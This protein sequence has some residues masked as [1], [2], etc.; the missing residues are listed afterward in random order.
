M[1]RKL[2]QAPSTRRCARFA[3]YLR[4]TP[5]ISNL[6]SSVS[7]SLSQVRSFSTPA[8]VEEYYRHGVDTNASKRMCFSSALDE[9]DPLSHE[10]YRYEV[11]FKAECSDVQF[12]QEGGFVTLDADEMGRVFPTG[13]AGE[14][15]GD[16]FMVRDSSK[17]LCRLMEDFESRCKIGTGVSSLPVGHRYPVVVPG[18][19]DLPQWDNSS[20]K[21]F[22]Y[23]NDD[24]NSGVDKPETPGG[25][26]MIVRGEGSMVEGVVQQLQQKM[27]AQL[28][29]RVMLTGKRGVG[30]S[31]ALNHA[32][33][34]ARTRGWICIFIPNG[35]SHVNG[36]AFIEPV[37]EVTGVENLFD[38]TM[39]SADLL[40]KF[41]F[42]HKEDL[43]D[44][45]LQFPEHAEKYRESIEVLQEAVTRTYG[46]MKKSGK[47]FTEIR[48][49]EVGFD[50]TFPD[51]DALDAPILNQTSNFDI[52]SFEIKTVEDLVLFGLAF[53]DFAGPVVLDMVRELRG[54]KNPDKPILIAIDQFNYWD[55]PT[56]YQYG[57]V[58]I[59][60]MDMCVP[61][62][63]KFLSEK[64]NSA[65]RWENNGDDNVMCIGATSHRYPI[66]K[67]KDK[68]LVTYENSR[69]SLP[70]S[71]D[72]GG[73]SHVE[74]L[75]AVKHYISTGRIDPGISNQDI[76]SFRMFCGNN[77]RT[78][79]REPS[80]FFL[81]LQSD[82]VSAVFEKITSSGGGGG[83]ETFKAIMRDQDPDEERHFSKEDVHYEVK[84]EEDSGAEGGAEKDCDVDLSSLNEAEV[85]AYLAELTTEP[86]WDD[87]E[88]T[89]SNP[90]EPRGGDVEISFG[91]R[92]DDLL[93]KTAD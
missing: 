14:L 28:P 42:A 46:S 4:S 65:T 32:V 68:K 39:M 58:K 86:V 78:M 3:S 25:E 73:Y 43:R 57:E 72:M 55:M 23:S 79:F 22:S 20:T 91:G 40:R 87:L 77:P 62:A 80:N 41:W 10:I 29:T 19:T 7:P 15:D 2:A 17:L 82:Y 66:N 36:G 48:M 56:V 11:D 71:I 21:V 49:A 16:A 31:C 34:H 13:M 61:H 50:D 8:S 63:L 12:T 64:K 54:Y 75:A 70:L 6:Y 18:L 67:K 30:K 53:R 44:I 33:Y 59:D 93:R 85:Q 51:E 90:L 74:F 35:W 92:Y 69:S 60:A 89:D 81:P 45:P 37:D 84:L 83:V 47:T 52:S 1:I 27:N 24:L 88:M 26:K 76:L 5:S 38:N 9:E